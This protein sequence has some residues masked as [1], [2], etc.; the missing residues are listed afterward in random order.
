MKVPYGY[1][2]RQFNAEVAEK[3]WQERIKEIVCNGDFTLGKA[4]NQFEAELAKF[5]GAK[6]AIGVANGTDALE[7]GLWACGIKP[8]MRVLVPANTFVASAAAICRVGAIPVFTDIDENYVMCM[9]HVDYLLQNYENISAVMPVHFG[10]QPCDMPR[11]KKILAEL[12]D[13]RRITVIED[14]AQSLNASI[15]GRDCGTM[16]DVGCISFHPQ[17][18]LNC[19]GDGGAIFTNNEVINE[20]LRLYR[21][22]G[23][24]DRD[25]YIYPSRNSRLD[26]IHAAVLSHCLND[27]HGANNR[28][29]EIAK[30]YDEAV[31]S[32]K[33][34][35]PK[36]LKAV[37]HTY[38]LYMFKLHGQ[39]TRDA[40]MEHLLDSGVDAKIHYPNILPDQRA[41]SASIYSL[42]KS[43]SNSIMRVMGYPKYPNARRFVET[44]ISLPIHQFMTDSEVNYI[45]ETL[46]SFKE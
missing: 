17:K 3:I 32:M 43:D 21:N 23:M 27:L 6:Y 40:L 28:R 29:I 18:N 5:A 25:T 38:H 42:D 39:T 16:G 30:A 11:L 14:S 2:D 7:M 44:A 33:W 26:S 35:H 15:E 31:S 13:E 20:K 19:W 36:R 10:G 34:I 22:H 8:G 37:R 24:L 12:N 46:K 9:N 1:L 45:I 4:V 41:F